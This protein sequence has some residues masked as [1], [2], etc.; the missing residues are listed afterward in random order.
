MHNYM[1]YYIKSTYSTTI[2]YKLYT[3]CRYRVIILRE[4]K[5]TYKNSML[6]MQDFTFLFLFGY[7][8]YYNLNFVKFDLTNVIWRI[9]LCVSVISLLG[10]YIFT[11]ISFA[12]AFLVC[13]S[14]LNHRRTICVRKGS[15][16]TTK[17]WL[18][19]E[20]MKGRNT[21]SGSGVVFKRTS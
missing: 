21:S 3:I 2:K 8:P 15:E 18:N 11:L 17:A 4:K 7:F 9:F 10:L 6:C 12:V 20:R 1:Q 14:Y 19:I 13:A 16:K 5:Y